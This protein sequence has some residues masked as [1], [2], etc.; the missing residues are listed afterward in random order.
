MLRRRVFLRTAGTALA[1]TAAFSLT[2]TVP[3]AAQAIDYTGKRIQ[4]IAPFTEGGGADGW[5]RMMAPFL[6]KHLPGHPRVLVLNKPGA[7]GITG[8][9]FF[10]EKA[11]KDGTSIFVLSVST[12]LAYALR[13]KRFKTK[14]EDYHP[15]LNAPRG[16]VLAA[17][18]ELGL[19]DVKSLKGKI[20]KLRD[21][22]IDRLAMGG[23]TPTSIDL[24]YMMSL[25]LLGVEVKSVW[26]LGG[27]GAISLGFERGEF[28]L[29]GENALTFTRLRGH[30]IAS[31]DAVP[32]YT[33]GTYDSEG[34]YGRDPVLPN[35]PTFIEAYEAVYGKKPSGPGFEAW[36]ALVG[37]DGPMNKSLVLHPDTPKDVVDTWVTSVRAMLAD[38]EFQKHAEPE[39]GPYQPIVGEAI[40]PIMKESFDIP[41]EARKWLAAYIKTRFNVTI[42][43]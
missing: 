42:A 39:L 6:E 31:G 15:V 24:A 40:R 8:A 13:D 17:R 33:W 11:P 9:N 10:Q 28:L 20:L 35:L 16:S 22:P 23:R 43:Q 3:G 27:G 5:A 18:K 29:M 21:Y 12:A 19:Q 30:L 2:V 25:S 1:V 34:K 32:L 37:V 38:K 4:I 14:F 7:G 26:G 41:P 36:K